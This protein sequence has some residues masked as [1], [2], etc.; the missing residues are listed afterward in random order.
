MKI[1][2]S[3]W[4]LYGQRLGIVRYIEYLIKY[5]K[6]HL[7]ED[8]EVILFVHTP[9]DIENTFPG[10]R[11][12]QVVIKPKLTNFLWENFLLPRHLQG[13]DILFGPSYTLPLLYRGKTV[14]A[15]HSVNEAEKSTHSL[16][17]KLTYSLKYKLSCKTADLVIANSQHIKDRIKDH[18]GIPADKIKVVWLGVDDAFQPSSDLTINK[19]KRI[20]YL[21]RDVPY[22]LFVGSLSE[23]KNVPLLMRAFSRLKTTTKLPHCLLLIGPNR[24]GISLDDFAKDLGISD[25][26]FQDDGIFRSHTEI[27]PIYNGADLFV[28]PVSSEGFS[29]TV[30]EA[31][32]C[33]VPVITSSSTTL[34]EI[35]N[36]YAH[37][38]P[39]INEK[40]LVN[41][42]REVLTND[43]YKSKLR[44]K[45]L[46]RSTVLRWRTTA[47]KMISILRDALSS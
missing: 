41:A 18:Y 38:I 33:G 2:I 10:M 36:G 26:L 27:I 34:G 12:R 19:E 14:V 35:A 29:L 20:N 39:E 16:F 3:A 42:M 1:G 25:S 9:I 15:I 47:G 4:R 7:H 5:W 30:A 40:S 31:M 46:E 44:E 23:R 6:C 24:T 17:H 13:I 43:K 32:A 8:D 11:V 22:I 45:G 28:Y 37:T 21:G